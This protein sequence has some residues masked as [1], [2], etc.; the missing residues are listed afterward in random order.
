[1]GRI[2]GMGLAAAA[3]AAAA[4]FLDPDRGRARRNQTRDQA[5]SKVRGGKQSVEGAATAASAQASGAAQK[6]AAAAREEEPPANDQTLARKVETEIFRDEDAP[7]GQ[8]DVDAA[9]G[10][11]T[12]RGQVDSDDMIEK[13]EK[14]TRK[15]TGVKDVQ[16]LL[17]KPG[18]P[19]PNV[20]S[21]TGGS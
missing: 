17:H 19:A 20:P 11:V 5:M 21:A 2:V 14:A 18:E 1:M 10:V 8:V 15:V 4:Y 3:G 9:D 16:N 6:A 7:K 12:L 13:L